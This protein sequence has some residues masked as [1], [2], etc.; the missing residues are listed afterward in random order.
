MQIVRSALRVRWSVAAALAGALA[1]LAP[2]P[3]MAGS[4][5]RFDWC[6]RAPIEITGLPGQCLGYYLWDPFAPHQVDP[7]QRRAPEA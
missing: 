3:V 4:D 2:Q 7:E 6:V 5:N 1:A